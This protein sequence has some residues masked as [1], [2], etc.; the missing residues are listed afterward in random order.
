M[1]P[2]STDRHLGEYRLRLLLA[3]NELTRTWLAEQVSVARRVLVDELRPE[4]HG[5]RDVFLA[6]VRAKAAVEHPL[7]ATVYEAVAEPEQCYFAYEI[8]PEVTFSDRVQT[9]ASFT[10]ARLVYLLR[11]ISEAHIHH[12]SL[13][14]ATAP[15]GLHNLHLDEHGGIR[16]ENLAIAGPRTE[17]Q[18]RR[19]IMYLGTALLPLVA[20][21]KPGATRMLTLLSWMRGEGTEES[22][23][24]KDIRDY[25]LQIEQQLAEPLPSASP[26]AAV[27][28]TAKKPPYILFSAIGGAIIILLLF[29][30][31]RPRSESARPQPSGSNGSDTVLIPAGRY[32]TPDATVE[33][34]QAF[35]IAAH[36]V[37]IGQY[38]EFLGLLETLS[39]NKRDRIFDHENQP[40]EKISHLPDDWAAL[41]AAAKSKGTWNK[42]RVTLDCPVVGVDWWD[43]S[44]YAEWKQARLATQEEWFAALNWEF[45][46]PA[47]LKPAGWIPANEE[48]TD[49][50]PKGIYTMAGG[51]GEWT[52]RPAPNP[53][54][55][56]GERKWIII[57]GS[58]LKPGSNALS[59]EWV[60]DRSLRR[61]DLGFRIVFDAK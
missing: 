44:A 19:D 41:L 48:T 13:G 31:L 15:L 7:V 46:T 27:P 51:V 18:T 11:R 61:P 59:R 47:D 60:D 53:N 2:D 25:C 26:T 37:T 24:W 28:A 16:L 57:G 36:E 21:G 38:A 45:K 4:Q 17:A 54:N 22:L 33:S 10:P 8:L 1:N 49:R 52:R 12:E 23:R 58:Y 43:C 35:K 32:P 39:K 6:N 55:P 29:L 50:T 42:R 56:L 3:E 40:P 30:A 14:Q 20:D 5:H 34:L 9:M